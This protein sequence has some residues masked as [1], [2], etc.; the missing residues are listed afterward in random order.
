[1][2]SDFKEIF[3]KLAKND[4]SDKMFLLT[5]KFHPLGVVSPCPGATCIYMYKTMKKIV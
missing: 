4:Q 5:W 1:M 3:L 2:K